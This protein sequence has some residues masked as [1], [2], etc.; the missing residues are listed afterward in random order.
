MER[1]PKNCLTDVA[2]VRVGHRTVTDPGNPAVQTGVT[3]ILPHG[4]NVFRE[5]LVAACHVVNGFAKPVGL[6]QLEEL[7]QLESPIALTN[8]L[9]VPAVTEGLLDLLLEENPDVGLGT[10]SANAVVAE[11]NDSLLNDM[12]GR[13]VR[14]EHVAE[15]VGIAS[16]E[17]A[18]Q[19]A[20]G[21]GRG[22]VAFGLKGGVGTAS[23]V[24]RRGDWSRTVGALVLSNFGSLRQLTVAGRPAGARFAEELGTGARGRGDSGAGSIVVVVATDAPVDSRQLGRLLRRVQ[25]GIARTGSTTDS[26][27]GDVAIGFTTAHRIPHSAS[28]PTVPVEMLREDGGLID[29]FFAAVTEATEEAI[30]NSVIN[31]EGVTGREGER[32]DGVPLDFLGETMKDTR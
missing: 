13:H 19:G 15:A 8:T 31:A 24:I 20:V 11:C 9:S 18:E 4:G 22:M 25:N 14:R 1:G 23:R 6:T 21:A 10:G 27:S 17:A 12:R 16:D 29:A 3:V 5:K 28:A 2:G 32:R 30:L 7:G 26:G